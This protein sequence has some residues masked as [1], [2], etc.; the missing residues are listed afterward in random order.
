MAKSSAGN[1]SRRRIFARWVPLCAFLALLPGTAFAQIDL[2]VLAGRVADSLS[3][4]RDPRY[5]TVA[6]YRIKNA[7]GRIDI[8]Q[9]IDFTNVKIVRSRRLSVID[10][11]RLTLILRE[12]RIQLGDFVSA[13]KYEELGRLLGVDLFVYGT[14]YQDALVLKAI[15]VQNSAIAWGDIFPLSE[16]A[17]EAAALLQLGGGVVNSLR[18]DLDRL[19]GAKIRQI[20]FWD[21]DAG[22]LFPSA[23]VIDYLSVV[24]TQDGNFQVVD[25][26]NLKVITREQ[27]LNQAVF[28]D[29]GSAKRLGELYGVDAF[30]YGGISQRADGT[31]I[32]SLKML[33]VF[34]GVIEWAD[35]I[36][37]PPPGGEVPSATASGGKGPKPPRGMALLPEGS[38]TMGANGEPANANPLR[39]VK[40]PAGFIDLTEVS[41][42]QYGRF[43]KERRHRA[44]VG[45][46]G[47]TYPRGAG[48]LPVVGISWSDA[49][50]YC[51]FMR[52]RLPREAE[53]EKAARGT[54]GRT[55]PWG[56]RTF[57]PGFAVTREAGPKG[58]VPVRKGTRD[59]SPYGVRHM[60]GNVREWVEDSYLPYRGNAGGRRGKTGERVVRGGS[61]ATRSKSAR[62]FARGSSNPN[63][64]WQDVGFR[65]AKTP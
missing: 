38:F 27:Q 11:S 28:I 15:D 8:P 20:S 43:V 50:R 6:F 48:S 55:Y 46:A 45:W 29:Q 18:K 60:A 32:A 5:K 56:G 44:P 12:Q 49:R 42:A 34:N 40:L 41:N 65:C 1:W 61:W 52:K 58:A 10:R 13:Q 31:I 2:E 21:L 9:L 37:I 30:L 53:W 4:I 22:D 25:R 51:R 19:R 26:E 16:N 64:A 36:K 54:D 35:L 62:T 33:N 63:L 17:P 14:L 3:K 39:G 7:G 59:V 47:G 23:A 24:I 57:T